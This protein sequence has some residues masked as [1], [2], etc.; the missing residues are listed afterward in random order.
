MLLDSAH[1]PISM[2]IRWDDPRA[3][4][5][6]PRLGL[7]VRDGEAFEGDP[8]KVREIRIR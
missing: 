4:I 7:G 8:V 2:H 5:P 1:G 3:R 6:D